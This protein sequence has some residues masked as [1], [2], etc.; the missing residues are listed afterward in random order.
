MMF[1]IKLTEE[2]FKTPTWHFQEF[3]G[4]QNSIFKRRLRFGFTCRVS[5]L[6]FT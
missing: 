2:A 3:V 6:P 1:E 5:N 4:K